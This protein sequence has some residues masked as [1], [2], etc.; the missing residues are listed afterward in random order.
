MACA[1]MRARWSGLQTIPVRWLAAQASRHQLRLN[2][3]QRTQRD[4]R[5]PLVDPFAVPGAFR[6]AYEQDC[7]RHG[8]HSL[9]DVATRPREDE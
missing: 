2:A 8:V 7:R 3:S 9:K 5:L 4:V 1:S 6:V